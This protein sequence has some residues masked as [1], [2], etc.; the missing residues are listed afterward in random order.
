MFP[1]KYGR[2]RKNC[3]DRD[4]RK[5]LKKAD[6]VDKGGWHCARRTFASHLLMAGADV[7]S[8]RII[9]GHSDLE[10]TKRYLSVTDKHLNEIV[11]LVGFTD[12][13]ERGKVLPF[14]KR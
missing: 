1:N 13:I 10:T 12:K 2:P 3:L 14:K 9:L 6:V 4:I 8:V 11:D 5:E 7:E